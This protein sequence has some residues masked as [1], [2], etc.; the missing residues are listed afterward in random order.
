MV[1][2]LASN[3]RVKELLGDK[4]YDGERKQ[5]EQTPTIASDRAF[6]RLHLQSYGP[7]RR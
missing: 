4:G 3:V 2:E 5:A 1:A 7:R 6:E